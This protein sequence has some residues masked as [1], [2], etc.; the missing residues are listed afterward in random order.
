MTSILANKYRTLHSLGEYF[1]ND[2]FQNFDLVWEGFDRV[3]KS[4]NIFHCGDKLHDIPVSIP[5]SLD[6]LTLRIRA[7]G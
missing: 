1:E 2:V 7:T 3:D 6:D 4:I 5:L